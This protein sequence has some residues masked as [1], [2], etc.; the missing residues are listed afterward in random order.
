MAP[1]SYYPYLYVAATQYQQPPCQYQPQKSN[2][3]SAPAQR[4]Q[5][6]QYNRDNKGQGRGQNNRNSFGN[7][8]QID[9]IS[10]PYAEL[11]PYLIHVGAIMPKEIP[12]ASPPFRPKHDPN[13]P[14]AYHVRFIGHSI[15][16]CWALKYKV[17]D[18]I[19]Q[20]ILSFSEEKPNVKTNPLPNHGGSA[21]NVVVEE[22][23]TES[24][25]RADDIKTP[26]SVVLK[27]L[28]QFGFLIGI[29]DDCVI[30]EY[31]I[32]NCDELRGCV[33][34]LMDQG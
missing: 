32:D 11:V 27:R 15:E 31:D 13:A 7:H 10:V 2:Q 28:E 19:N 21:V 22:E 6:Q 25:L 14:C 23:T 16:Y 29:H 18:L 24:I 33:E 3:Q 17:Q 4:N 1:M 5:N 34:K 12:G 26:L 8:P 30:C 9:K 20:E